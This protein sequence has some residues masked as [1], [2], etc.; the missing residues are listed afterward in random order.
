[1]KMSYNRKNKNYLN[2]PNSKNNNVAINLANRFLNTSNPLLGPVVRGFKKTV[3]K[4]RKKIGGKKK[5]NKTNKKQNS[6]K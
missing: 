5:L 6:K 2:M 4:I 1:M 3:K